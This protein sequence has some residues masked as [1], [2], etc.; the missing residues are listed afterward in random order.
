MTS[1]NPDHFDHSDHTQRLQRAADLLASLGEHELAG[2]VS[3][4]RSLHF[5]LIGRVSHARQAMRKLN[6]LGE[7]GVYLAREARGV[8]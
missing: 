5:N 8:L 1:K 7:H 2:A 4:A 3:R 6:W